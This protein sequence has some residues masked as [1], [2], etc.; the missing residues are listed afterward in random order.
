[1]IL[2]ITIVIVGLGKSYYHS[3]KYNIAY[4]IWI[5]SPNKIPHNGLSSKQINKHL[6]TNSWLYYILS[7]NKNEKKGFLT[8]CIHLGILIIILVDWIF[9]YSNCLYMLS[10]FTFLF[11]FYFQ[12]TIRMKEWEC[13][14]LFLTDALYFYKR[15][16]LLA[17]YFTFISLT[18]VF[19]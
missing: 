16:K 2:E 4:G 19:M 1:M 10:I 5:D 14:Y 7:S 15:L 13:A 12:Y 8:W 11:I 3:S 18:L 9:T 17:S 6:R